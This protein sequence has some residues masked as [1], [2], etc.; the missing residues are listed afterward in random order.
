MADSLPDTTSELAAN[1]L[2][3]S[4]CGRP[5]DCGRFRA[6]DG[7]ALCVLAVFTCSILW[8]LVIGRSLYWG[9][10]ALYFEPMQR[11]ASAELRAGRIPLWNPYLLCGQPFL[12]N[13]QMG[14]FYPLSFTGSLVSASR[15]IAISTIVHMFLCGLFMYIFVRR[16]ARHRT[17]ALCAA[18]TYMG[19]TCIVGRIQFPPMIVSAAYCPLIL[20]LVDSC[21]ERITIRRWLGLTIAVGLLALSAHPQMAYLTLL[22]ST[23][24]AV[25]R[26]VT[27]TLIGVRIKLQ[28]ERHSAYWTAFL[29]LSKLAG[30]LGAGL[31]IAAVQLAP[32]VELARVSTRERMTPMAANRFVFDLSHLVT[33]VMPHAF[34]HPARSDYF[35]GGNAWEPGIF[36][37]WLPL[38]A[39][40]YAA[41]IKWRSIQVRF[42]IT[43]CVVSMWLATGTAGGLFWIAFYAVPGLSNFHDPARFL[44]LTTVSL[45]ALTFMGLDVWL[46]GKGKAAGLKAVGSLLI[47]AIPLIWFGVEWNPTTK[48]SLDHGP[49]HA[50]SPMDGRSYLPAHDLY[51]KRFVTDGYSDYGTE[52]NLSDIL[53]TDTPNVQMREGIETA[54]GYEPVPVSAPAEIDGLTRLA[55]RRDE[56]TLTSLLQVMDVTQVMLP[57]YHTI[58]SSDLFKIVPSEALDSD[59]SIQHVGSGSSRAWLVPAAMHIEGKTR[60]EAVMAGPDFDPRAIAVVSGMRPEQALSLPELSTQQAGYA[61]SVHIISRST[62]STLFDVDVTDGCGFMV[63]SATCYPGWKATMDGKRADL[64]CADGAFLG[65]EVPHGRHRVRIYYAPAAVRLGIYILA[66]SFMAGAGMFTFSIMERAS[67]NKHNFRLHRPKSSRIHSSVI[68]TEKGAK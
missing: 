60:V 38:I 15:F 48:R 28:A 11:F 25:F 52:A 8:P 29:T 67:S 61:G 30:A 24:Y 44:F 27:S 37:G 45:C 46:D 62:T 5:I 54:A 22:L 9:D 20:A 23:V 14:V 32:M 53:N 16:W 65:L 2:P 49:K 47:T 3:G 6:K 18:L 17:S 1:I 57:E 42:W 7:A 68:V 35:G 51:W 10:I 4:R 66:V 31:M 50:H 56:P 36:I 59:I 55:F 26:V 64:H 33:L 34:G 43:V 40:A 21:V 12:G 58:Y 41:A 39:I 13:P 19:S 63:Y